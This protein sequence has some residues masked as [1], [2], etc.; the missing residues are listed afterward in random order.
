MTC[1]G[2]FNENSIDILLI[3]FIVKEDELVARWNGCYIN[4]PRYHGKLLSSP[5][6]FP[7]V[8]KYVILAFFFFL[9]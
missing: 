3:A 6:P 9:L 7:K 5:N 4:F 2:T 8:A 1:E